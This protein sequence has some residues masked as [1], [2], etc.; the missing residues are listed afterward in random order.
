MRKPL[1][2]GKGSIHKYPATHLRRCPGRCLDY[3]PRQYS[4]DRANCERTNDTFPLRAALL[5]GKDVS[6]AVQ[7]QGL[8]PRAFSA[9]RHACELE[10]R[11]REGSGETPSC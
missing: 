8:L 2:A 10:A 3:L 7:K 9:R 1:T 5:L 6:V 11:S 4:T